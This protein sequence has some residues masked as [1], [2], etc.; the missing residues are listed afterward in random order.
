MLL[1]VLVL[2]AKS[3]FAMPKLFIIETSY[4]L[5]S[6]LGGNADATDAEIWL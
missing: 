6:L 1:K 3:P 5:L 4:S 2:A